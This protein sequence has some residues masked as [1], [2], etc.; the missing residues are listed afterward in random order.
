MQADQAAVVLQG[1]SL[2]TRRF[3]ALL[4]AFL[5]KV[6]RADLVAKLTLDQ[7]GEDQYTVWIKEEGI[8]VDVGHEVEVK[9]IVKKL[10]R[11][12]LRVFTLEVCPGNRNTPPEDVDKTQ[13]ETFHEDEAL[14]CVASLL[15]TAAI[16]SLPPLSEDLCPPAVVEENAWD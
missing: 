8:G 15:A 16:M 7:I 1:A 12:G 14:V 10:T 5:P 6:G 3:V 11:P 9:S 13:L 4:S 2:A